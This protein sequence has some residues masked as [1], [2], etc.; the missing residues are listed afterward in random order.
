M[1]PKLLEADATSIRKEV[2]WSLSNVTAGTRAQIQAV[3]NAG[4]LPKILK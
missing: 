2:C 3:I 1:C 4:L